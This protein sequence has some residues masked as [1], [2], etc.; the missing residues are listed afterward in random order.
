MNLFAIFAE[1]KIKIVSII[2]IFL[3]FFGYF[4]ESI[5]V[6]VFP[7]QSGVLFRPMANVAM[8]SK[9]YAEGIYMIAP[10][11][12][13]YIYDL[14]KQRLELNVEALTSNGLKVGL[15]ITSIFHPDGAR[16]TELT[17]HVG[18]NYVQK[19]ITP[20]IYSSSRE[21]IGRYLPEELYTTAMH[22][23]Q[24]QILEEVLR[25]SVDLPFTI[26]DVVVEKIE[27]PGSINKAIE[28]KLKH[29]Q[30]ALAYQYILI[31]EVDEARRRK[32]EAE[33]IQAYNNKIKDSLNQDIL[34]WF[35]VKALADLGKSDNSKVIV[36]EGNSQTTPVV[37]N[38]TDK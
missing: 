14:T 34:Q 10:W 33:S 8:Q 3:F 30:D 9:V 15:R 36:L 20:T 17:K 22:V 11:D 16:L 1:Y 18:L 5:F 19:I 6:Y 38:P 31:K 21:I 32:I 7:G 2:F 37:I 26:E 29:Q 27:L 23:I 4:F 35:K 12:K 24:D 25:E 13:M 28:A